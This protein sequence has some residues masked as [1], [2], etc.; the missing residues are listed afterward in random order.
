MS[1]NKM[2][3]CQQTT[4]LM[5]PK[6]LFSVCMSIHTI[7]TYF[8]MPYIPQFCNRAYLSN[9]ECPQRNIFPPRHCTGSQEWCTGDHLQIIKYI[10]KSYG[11]ENCFLIIGDNSIIMS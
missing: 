6:K 4:D 10:N 5:W 11:N 3:R 7:F 1:E 2:L 9:R 8:L